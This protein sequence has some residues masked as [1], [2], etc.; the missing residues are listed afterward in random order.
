[1]NDAGVISSLL[2]FLF[3]I[4]VWMV[5]LMIGLYI[6]FGK[7]KEEKISYP[8]QN[9]GTVSYEQAGNDTQSEYNP[10]FDGK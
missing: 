8:S 10:L 9:M 5:G 6:A 2:E 3:T 7:V 4:L 1:M